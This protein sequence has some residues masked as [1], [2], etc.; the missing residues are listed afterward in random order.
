MTRYELD[1]FIEFLRQQ[2]LVFAPQKIDNELK[3]A[4]VDD[5]KDVLITSEIPLHSF[6]KY[7]LPPKESLFAF[8]AGKII[9]DINSPQQVLFGLTIVDLK[10]VVLL[11]QVF[12]HDPYY[13]ERLKKTLVVG[14]SLVPQE[15]YQFF[16]EKFEENTLEHLQFDIFLAVQG[17]NFKIYTGSEEGQRILDE[18]G[19][20]DFENVQY[21]GYLKEEGSDLQMQK[22]SEAMQ[23]GNFTDP[24]WQEL[25]KI[26]IECGKCTAVC[27]CCF[28][29]DV[30]DEAE[31]EPK[32]G[33]RKRIWSS[34][35]YTD[36][37]EI[38]G[39]KIFGSKPKFLKNTAQRIH[40]WYEHK[41]VRMPHEF[42]LQG[43]VGC[44]RCTKVCPVG[45]DIKKNL[46]ELLKVKKI[47]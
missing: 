12:R 10:S 5:P 23:Q 34:C 29:F 8:S 6:K 37:S 16:I 9:E 2:Y 45:I 30:K 27:P 19:L 33:V 13:Q 22:I 14:H 38:A 1:K 35:F 11:N 39:P 47:K 3:F 28:C 31:L 17:K 32:A 44:G 43:C 21:T 26:C 41:F 18:F 15:K 46:Q 24:L 20:K 36:F 40:F 7:L 25:G 42:K 4:P